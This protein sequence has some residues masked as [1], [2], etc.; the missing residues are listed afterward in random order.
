MITK[1][2][3]EVNA[4]FNPFSVSAKPARLFLTYL[5]PNAR[6]SGMT[7]NTKLL[8]RNSTEPNSLNVKF[9]DGKI[10]NF[11]CDKVNIKGLAAECDRHSRQLQKAED[12]TD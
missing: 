8:P 2:I 7:I 1:F 5:P 6:M 9:K 10:M 12:L 4:K 3:T 11:D